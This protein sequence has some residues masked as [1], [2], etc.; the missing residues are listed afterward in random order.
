MSAEKD[1]AD[2]PSQLQQFIA[3][4]NFSF[5]KEILYMCDGMLDVFVGR[6]RRA[7]AKTASV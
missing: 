3:G 5:C 6:N 2:F 4:Q 1:N 7:P